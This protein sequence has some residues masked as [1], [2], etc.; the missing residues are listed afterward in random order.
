[1][2]EAAARA[3]PHDATDH[4]FYSE[5]LATMYN[6]HGAE[7]APRQTLTHH[8]QASTP[9]GVRRSRAASSHACHGRLAAF[10]TTE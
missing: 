3:K 1:M 6:T 5:A 4:C 8:P 2:V 10:I 7:L 9:P